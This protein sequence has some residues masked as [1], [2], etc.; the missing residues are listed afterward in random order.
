MCAY[1]GLL[2][3]SSDYQNHLCLRPREFPAQTISTI[4]NPDL[5]YTISCMSKARASIRF[6]QAHLV[7]SE[8]PAE[9]TG[10]WGEAIEGSAAL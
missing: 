9:Q 7:V 2:P 3:H 10:V 4:R 6:T 1:S 8:E 5:A